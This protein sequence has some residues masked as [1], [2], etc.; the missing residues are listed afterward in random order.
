MSKNH[1]NGP[2]PQDPPLTTGQH[3]RVLA[4]L[5]R[6]L[7]AAFPWYVK[8]AVLVL[9]L[10]AW[11]AYPYYQQWSVMQEEFETQAYNVSD[12]NLD[13]VRSI[14]VKSRSTYVM[15]PGASVNRSCDGGGNFASKRGVTLRWAFFSKDFGHTRIEK[16]TDRTC[17][18]KSFD[19]PERKPGKNYLYIGVYGRDTLRVRWGDIRFIDTKI[20]T[21]KFNPEDV[22]SIGHIPLPVNAGEVD[23]TGWPLPPRWNEVVDGP[24]IDAKG[25]GAWL[26]LKADYSK[27]CEDEQ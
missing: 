6:G 14:P 20:G 13:E 26:T 9:P 23:E 27:P 5:G 4:F 8:L 21:G 10:A 18:Y 1:K 11:L 12:E 2:K 3:L 19:L 25:N 24:N 7:V 17:Y 15:C 22:W 16:V